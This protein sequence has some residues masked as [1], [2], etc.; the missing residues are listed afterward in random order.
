MDWIGVGEHCHLIDSYVGDKI[1]GFKIFLKS[2]LFLPSV[3]FVKD[4]SVQK[5]VPAMLLF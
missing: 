2:V 1:V 3:C 4:T 5:P